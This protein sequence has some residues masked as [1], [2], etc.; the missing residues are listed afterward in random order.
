MMAMTNSSSVLSLDGNCHAKS[1][2]R[3]DVMICNEKDRMRAGD[4]NY[5]KGCEPTPEGLLGTERTSN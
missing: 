5:H 1:S 4:R 2:K 3:G